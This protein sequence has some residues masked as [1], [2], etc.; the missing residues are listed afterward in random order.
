MTDVNIRSLADFKRF[1]AHP[2]ATIE[3]LRNDVMTRN[4]QTPETRP[5]AYGTRQVKKLQ[6]NAVQFT[7]NNWL[8]F[9]K[10][11]EYRFSG[12]VVTIDVSKDGS[13]KDVIEYKLSVQPAA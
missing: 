2:G 6:T 7:G 13:F 9:G 4:G 8:W 1:L 11:A 12:D 10:A 3:T 5:H